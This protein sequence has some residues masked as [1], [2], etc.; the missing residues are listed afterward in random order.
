MNEVRVIPPPLAKIR[1]VGNQYVCKF[2]RQYRDGKWRKFWAL[3]NT[4]VGLE[5]G[6]MLR[7]LGHEVVEEIKEVE[8]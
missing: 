5:V 6:D 8:D 3:G 2:L 4:G 7:K 1:I